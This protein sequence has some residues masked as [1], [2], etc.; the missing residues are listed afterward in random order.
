MSATATIREINNRPIWWKDK[1]DFVHICEGA[2]VHRD[3]RLFW[4][5][6]ERD[7]PANTGFHPGLDERVTCATCLQRAKQFQVG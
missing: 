6:C 5:L 4:T 1:Q 7:V 2:D 3:V